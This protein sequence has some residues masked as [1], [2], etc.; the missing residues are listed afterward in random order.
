MQTQQ[1]FWVLILA[2][3]NRKASQEATEMKI[4]LGVLAFPARAHHESRVDTLNRVQRPVIDDLWISRSVSELLS[5]DEERGVREVEA[6]R[7]VMPLIVANFGQFP[8]IFRRLEDCVLLFV[9]LSAK[10]KY[11]SAVAD[12]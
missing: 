9:E 10:K 1:D 6:N 8:T 5:V 11:E 12:E 7:E 2:A 3:K 4:H